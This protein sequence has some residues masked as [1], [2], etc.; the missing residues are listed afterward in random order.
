LLWGWY[1]LKKSGKK[2]EQAPHRVPQ[3]DEKE[4]KSVVFPSF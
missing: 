4:G 3:I 1:G 2:A